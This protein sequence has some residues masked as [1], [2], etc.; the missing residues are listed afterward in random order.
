MTDD[1]E[2]ARPAP[3][4]LDDPELFK[5]GPL[6]LAIRLW[7]TGDIRADATQVARLREYAQAADPLADAVVEMIAALPRGQGRSLFEQALGEGIDALGSPPEPLVDFFRA[8]EAAPYWLDRERLDRGGRAILRTGLL[9]MFPLGDM[10]LMGG[11]LASRAVKT[12]VGTGDLEHMAVRRLIETAAWWLDVTTPGAMKPGAEGYRAALRVRL[13]HAHVRAAM[14]GRDDWD[15]DAWD[16]P[17]NQVQT[18]GTLLLFSQVFVV[19]TQM[20]G[21]RYSEREREDIL[22][23]WRYIGWLMGVDDALLPANEEDSWRLLWLLAATEFIP[24]D[25]SKRLAQALL[26]THGEIGKNF[27]PLAGVV[28]GASV[29]L[30]AAISR[31]L[32]GNQNADFLGLPSARV[33]R[34]AVLGL[35]AANF[36]VETARRRLPGATVVQERVGAFTRKQYLARLGRMVDLDRTYASHMRPGGSGTATNAA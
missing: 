36:A 28:S 6:R 11:Y 19:G 21:V 14:N 9:G 35:S 26:A 4:R 22:H 2:Q 33:G 3:E 13:V 27:G 8:V 18:V 24:D 15:Y 16:Y 25:D 31:M 32:I 17:V 20:L 23:L 1:A 29:R 5:R 10:S 30:H 34:L 7:G 12:L